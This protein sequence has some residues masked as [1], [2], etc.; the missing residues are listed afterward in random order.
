MYVFMLFVPLSKNCLLVL[1]PLVQSRCTHKTQ[2][3]NNGKRYSFVC[4]SSVHPRG[5]IVQRI[6]DEMSGHLCTS[7]T[8]SVYLTT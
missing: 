7:S 2:F 1:P 3:K 8:S 6:L 4:L 5:S